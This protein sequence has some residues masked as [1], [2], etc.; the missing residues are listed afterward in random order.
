MN[1]QLIDTEIQQKNYEKELLLCKKAGGDIERYRCLSFDVLQLEQ[2]RRGLESGVDVERYMDPKKS[3][4][5]MEETRVS[6]ETGF[7]MQ[8]YLNQ[9]YNWMQCNEIRAGLQAGLKI[10]LYLDTT[11]LAAQMK[12]IRKG[13]QKKV[14]VSYYASPQFDWF[15]MK[16]IRL[17]LEDKM[18]VSVYAKPSYNY[19]T[20]RA[21]RKGLKEEIDLTP[22]LEKGYSGNILYEISRGIRM[23]YDIREYLEE[24][25]DAEQLKQINNAH[26]QGLNLVP[27][28]H[29]DF[30]GVQLEEIIIG[31]KEGLDVKRYAN[32][33]FNWFQM[34]E[35]RYGLERKIDVSPY[36]MPEFSPKQMQVIRKGI[37]EGVDV[38]K[39][40]KVY[41]EPEQMEEILCEI[42]QFG[43]EITQEMEKIMQESMMP[44]PSL[45]EEIVE[46]R[47]EKT[48]EQFEEEVSDNLVLDSCVFVSEDKMSVVVDFSTVQDVM[49]KELEAVKVPDVIR[50][51]KHHDVSQGIDRESIKKMLDKKMFGEGVVV[52]RGKAAEDGKDG[53]FQYY[54]RKE[55]D[56]KPKVLEDGSVD[57]KSMEL[58]EVVQKDMLLAEYQPAT[59]GIFGFDVT[60]KII[61][62]K[63]G[64]ELPP[65]KGEGFTM[66]EDKKKYFALL[67]GIVELDEEDQKMVIRNLYTVT[68][69][70]DASVG[71]ITFNGDVNVM[72]NVQAGFSISA[73]GSVVID[74]HCEGCQIEA[75]K[76]VIIRKGYQGKGEGIVVAGGGITGQFFESA[77]LKAAGDIQ[78]S[79]L[80]NCDLHTTGKLLVEGRRGVIIGGYTCAKKGVSCF[81]IGNIAEIKT[82]VEVGIDKEDM[83]AYQESIKKVGKV[84]AELKTCEDALQ[85]LMMQ[86][87]RDER[88]TAFIE[89]L[90]KAVYTKKAQKKELLQARSEQMDKMT[91]QRGAKISVSGRAF[92]GTILYMNTAPFALKEMYKGVDFVSRDNKVDM[93][94]K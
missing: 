32:P 92:P 26:E 35:I 91:K 9:G 63:R 52:A 2:I 20:M 38:E 57:Y 19:T 72:G 3:W 28:I 54:F 16:E 81:G 40:A 73:T 70:V 79:Y 11:Y 27:Y 31:L 14:D 5:E 85:K 66:T 48:E 64:K 12:E 60:G 29:K 18:D 90:I 78:A 47:E 41:Y 55:L 87:N 93:V 94:T 4:L 74:G 46:G 77:I 6:M 39:Y 61:A 10:S 56:R 71:N 69:D 89:Q 34:R 15:Q 36:A 21:I 51:L 1:K 68:G 67:D 45:E 43:T 49:K 37:L 33:I 76:D 62:P 25:Y 53:K 80:L 17:G 50:A 58:F 22:Y 7:D 13:L 75:G 82:V 42:E 65:L 30:H 84:E 8:G 86:P 88:A 24:G 23:N 44:Q 59:Q 83:M